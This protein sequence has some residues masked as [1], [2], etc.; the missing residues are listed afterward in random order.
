M[1]GMLTVVGTVQREDRNLV[2]YHHV[3]FP[4]CGDMARVSVIERG[5]LNKAPLRLLQKHVAA[6]ASE[7]S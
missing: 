4:F 6:P 1:P 5:N 2:K 7:W 3:P